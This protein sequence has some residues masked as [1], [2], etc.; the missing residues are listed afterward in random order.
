MVRIKSVG[1]AGMKFALAVADRFNPITNDP[2]A[3]LRTVAF[4]DVFGPSL[5]PRASAHQGIATGIAVLTAEIVGKGVDSAIRRVVPNTSPFAMRVGSRAAVAA[6]GYGIGRLPQSRDESTTVAS[7]RTAGRLVMAGAVGGMVHQTGTEL[8]ERYPATGPL[9]PIVTGLGGLAGAMLYTDKLLQTR[10]GLIKR[11]SEDD[12]PSS[13]PASIAIGL[14]I[15]YGGKLVGKGF[16]ASRDASMSYFGDTRSKRL[17]GRSVNLAIWAAGSAGLYS[18]V[19]GLIARSNE[20]I[21]PAYSEEPDNSYVSGGPQSVSPFHE[22]G[23]QGRRYVTDVMSPELID[24]TLGEKGAIHP[25]RAYIGYNSEPLYSTGRSEMALDELAGLGAF[26]RKYLL[27]FSPTGTGWVDQTMIESAEVLARGDIATCCVQYGR[28]PSFL[29][30]QKVALGRQQF[31]QLLWGIKQRLADRPE[32]ERPKVLVFGESLGAWS[33]SDVVMKRGMAG[34]DQYGIDRALWFG[35]PGLAQWSKNG[36]R[37]GSSNLVPEGT[38]GAF[39]RHEQLAALSDEE[40]D[41]LRAV[42]LDHDNDP[43]AQISFRLA[44]KQPAW[45]DS[46]P[47][48][49][50]VPETMVWTPLLTFVQVAVDAMNAMRV[51]PGHFKSFGHDYRGDTAAFVHTAF[52]FDSATEEQMA[53]LDNTLKQLELERGERIK[54]SKELQA[55]LDADAPKRT[56]GPRYLRDRVAGTMNQA[57]I[58]ATPGAA[59]ADYQ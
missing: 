4:I 18:A 36:M 2:S 37:D 25:I 42:I 57:K 22:L 19:V 17:I 47:R 14:G 52:H 5:M 39:D 8:R 21:E 49:R 32:N 38:V 35:L 55:E 7:V 26:D 45:L 20:K 16:R 53:K 24:E 1:G 33:S 11:W 6:V 54:A 48:G 50:N 58:E 12:T 3:P 41:K 34:F 43:I 13:L 31:R 28:S 40:R 29:A 56:A 46:G 30:L 15:S 10:H 51:I 59:Q 9:R 23:L 27:L 44:V